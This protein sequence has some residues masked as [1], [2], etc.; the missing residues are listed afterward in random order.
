MCESEPADDDTYL[1]FTTFCAEI[2]KFLDI[3]AKL[4]EPTSQ[5]TVFAPVDDAFSSLNFDNLDEKHQKRIIQAHI[6]N[7]IRDTNSLT[8]NEVIQS[9][10]FPG[11]SYNNRFTS[12]KSKTICDSGGKSY[13]VGACNVNAGIDNR[14]EIGGPKVFITGSD[15]VVAGSTTIT[16]SATESREGYRQKVSC[17]PPKWMI[18][19]N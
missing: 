4:R 11:T 2:D 9:A 6:H 1:S 19:S 17:F 14:P 7:T 18:F 10:I 13:Q 3:K 16:F 8:C 5:V 15:T 12:V